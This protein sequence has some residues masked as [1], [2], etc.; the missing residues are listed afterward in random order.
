MRTLIVL[1]AAAFSSVQF[2]GCTVIGFAV[3]ARIDKENARSNRVAWSEA[4][5]V[6]KGRT[7]AVT[8]TSGDTLYGRFTGLSA[9]P[10]DSYR[11]LYDS[12]RSLQDGALPRLGEDISVVPDSGHSYS[13]VFRGFDAEALVVRRTSTDTLSY[14]PLSTISRLRKYNGRPYNL[15]RL[16][17]IASSRALPSRNEFVMR[18]DGQ[19]VNVPLPQ[20]REVCVR[21]CFTFNCVLGAAAGLAIDAAVVGLITVSWSNTEPRSAPGTGIFDLDWQHW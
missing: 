8:L 18:S 16:R 19:T 11:F 14:L 1:L 13:G 5:T 6:S 10:A 2:S 9:L 12:L 17:A 7:V 3:G 4:K 21:P 15:S 20:I